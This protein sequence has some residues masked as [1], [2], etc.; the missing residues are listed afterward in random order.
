MKQTQTSAVKSRKP[1]IIFIMADD[2]GYNDL[3]CYGQKNIQTPNIDHL[4]VEGI[5][6][7]Q[8]YAGSPICA[9][10]RNVLMTGQ[11][12]GHTRIRGNFS[13]VGGALV[14]D[15]GSPQRRVPLEPE[16]VTVAE[17]LKKGGYVTGMTGKWGL[18][19]PGTT[20]VPNKK[21][22][23]EWF[24][25]INQ[26]RAHT[27][28]PPYLWHNE[29]KVI[30]EGNQDGR[31]EQYSHDMF[32]DFALNFIREHKDRP[33]LLYLP[34]CIPHAQYEIPSIEPYADKPWP[35][36]AKVHAAMIT[37]MDRDVGRI[38]A[39]LKELGIDEH[40]IVFF[41]SD[42]GASQYWEG[43]FDSSGP[44]RGHKGELYEGGIRT[45]MLVRWPNQVPA[46]VVSDK[47]WYFAD[48]LPTAVE[49]AGIETSLNIDGVSVLPT[50]LGKEQN[51]EERFLYWEFF[52]R[53]FQQVARIDDWKGVRL[54]PKEPLELYDLSEDISEQNDVA[55]QHPEVAEKISAYLENAH[56][57]SKNWPTQEY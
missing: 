22:F 28:Y 51:L 3:G 55:E 7:T 15:N 43:I 32:S 21:G 52:G 17:V 16:D 54:V 25:Y 31:R 26:R 34:W 23:D 50:L 41:C 9:P 8:C 13:K 12:T 56:T 6:F 18:G 2:L 39:L 38:M 27:Y 40:T 20:G 10:S 4:A 47:V 5:L 33:F 35:P 37:R 48:F 24:G 29:E 42:N 44:L 30:L 45:P 36:E 14:L 49:L 57:E 53:H 1:N 11:H 19:E 46:G